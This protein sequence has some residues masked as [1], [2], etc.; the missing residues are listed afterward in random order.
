[1]GILGR[2]NDAIAAEIGLKQ[3]ERAARKW[4]ATVQ[5]NVPYYPL[6]DSGDVYTFTRTQGGIPVTA[7]GTK[8]TRVFWDHWTDRAPQ[9]KIGSPPAGWIPANDA[10]R[11]AT[12]NNRAANLTAHHGGRQGN[13]K[14]KAA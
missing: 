13:G 14:E 12:P 1:M 3:V 9:F 8:A 5:L 11:V 7:S 2:I 6:D 4:A 10:R